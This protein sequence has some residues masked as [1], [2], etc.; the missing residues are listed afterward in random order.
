MLISSATPAG[1]PPTVT[2]IAPEEWTQVEIRLEDFPTPTPEPIAGLVFVAEVPVGGF[3]F[4]VDKEEGEVWG[5]RED[6]LRRLLVVL[7]RREGWFAC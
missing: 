6:G 4:E 5:G 7:R 1:P 3:A 2:F